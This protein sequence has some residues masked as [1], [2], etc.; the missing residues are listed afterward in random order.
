MTHFKKDFTSHLLRQRRG[1]E[2]RTE[3]HTHH[4]LCRRRLLEG[5][6]EERDRGSDG[7][8][9]ER[10]KSRKLKPRPQLK[11]EKARKKEPPLNTS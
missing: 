6:S 9:R 2:G 1:R 11:R 4:G 10:E 5:E 7:G 3:Y 8:E